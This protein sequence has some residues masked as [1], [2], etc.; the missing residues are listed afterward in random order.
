MLC[1]VGRTALC[2][3]SSVSRTMSSSSYSYFSVA[4]DNERMYRDHGI[5]THQAR[6]CETRARLRGAR[7]AGRNPCPKA[8]L[9]N[10]S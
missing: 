2:A 8:T 5:P 7:L 1:R 4:R 6:V 10:R 9:E 3:A